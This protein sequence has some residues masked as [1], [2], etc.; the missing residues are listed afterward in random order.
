MNTKTKK[1]LCWNCEGNVAIIDE[2][3]PYCGVSLDVSPMLSNAVGSD[4]LN[5]PYKYTQSTSETSIPLAPYRTEEQEPKAQVEETLPPPADTVRTTHELQ[6]T[7]IALSSLLLGFTLLLFSA[8]LLLFSDNNGYLTL[9]W[10]A[11]FWYLYLIVGAPLLYWGWK[12]ASSLDDDSD[13]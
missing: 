4:A 13:A 3:C 2:T 6:K 10:S 1:K 12:T 9:R 8:I 5:P 11:D 7:A